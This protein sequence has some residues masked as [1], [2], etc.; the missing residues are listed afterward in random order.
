METSKVCPLVNRFMCRFLAWAMQTFL[1][2]QKGWRIFG[3]FCLTTYIASGKIDI[4]NMKRLSIDCRSVI[5]FLISFLKKNEKKVIQAVQQTVSWTELL[6]E[7]L[8]LK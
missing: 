4:I 2:Q 6:T 8:L 3:N 5:A 7:I 1:L